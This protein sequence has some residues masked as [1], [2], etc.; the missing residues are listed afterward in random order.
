MFILN[1]GGGETMYNILEGKGKY[2]WI[3]KQTKL[4]THGLHLCILEAADDI[5]KTDILLG[6]NKKSACSAGSD[7]KV[8]GPADAM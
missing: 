4:N 6:W 5:I 2:S 8:D 3:S 7:K 1:G